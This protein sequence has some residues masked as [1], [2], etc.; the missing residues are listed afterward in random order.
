M[1]LPIVDLFIGIQE[2]HSHQRLREIF[3]RGSVLAVVSRAVGDL[4]IRE[5]AEIPI[6]GV[7]D[8]PKP[9]AGEIPKRGRVAAAQHPGKP[10]DFDVIAEL[11]VELNPGRFICS[12]SGDSSS[13]QFHFRNGYA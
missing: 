7:S 3:W 11:F 2:P 5:P 8:G 9:K 6:L 1:N 4:F 12:V 10:V 13:R